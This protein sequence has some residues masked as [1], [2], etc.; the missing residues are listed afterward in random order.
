[1]EGER[2]I[3]EPTDRLRKV[4]RSHNE[5]V[6]FVL[7]FVEL[8]QECIYNLWIVNAVGEAVG[9]VGQTLRPSEGSVPAMAAA[10]AAVKDSTS[11][12][13]VE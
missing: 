3:C 2:L 9:L 11:S 6:L 10:R 4:A 1:M 8:S 12:K 7:E 13:K 5:N